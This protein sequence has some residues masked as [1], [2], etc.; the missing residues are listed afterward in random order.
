MDKRV[1]KST[2]VKLILLGVALAAPYLGI[3]EKTRDILIRIL[4]VW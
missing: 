1:K 3:D 2:L 4:F